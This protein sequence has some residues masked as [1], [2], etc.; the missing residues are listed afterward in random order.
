MKEETDEVVDVKQAETLEKIID[1]KNSELIKV[2]IPKDEYNDDHG[3]NIE[4]SSSSEGSSSSAGLKNKIKKNYGYTFNIDGFELNSVAYFNEILLGNRTPDKKKC[5]NVK[6]NFMETLDF[7]LKKTYKTCLTYLEKI[8]KQDFELQGDIDGVIINVENEVI[9][10]AKKDNPYSIFTSD[11]FLKHKKTYDIF[12]ESTFGLFDKLSKE[13]SSGTTRKIIQLKKLIFLIQFIKE[14]NCDEIDGSD[15]GKIK[16]RTE[17]NNTFHHNP[18]NDILLCIIV[19]GNYMQL[20]KQLMNTCL[21]AKNWGN[22]N[23]NKK[24][25]N[26]YEY[27]KILRESKVPF[28]IVYCP[29]FYERSSQFFNPISKKYLEDK[30]MESEIKLNNLLNENQKLK[31]EIENQNAKIKVQDTKIKEQDTKIKEQDTKLKKQDTKIEELEKKFMLME[32]KK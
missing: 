10:N 27:F 30:E 14:I 28:L 1:P 8:L 18:S 5:F 2:K 21:F 9:K 23:E 4:V 17:F 24:M 7:K 12:C 15:E 19:D 32:M 29:R 26:L 11:N 25:P 13:K 3:S 31:Q 22:A 16:F 20:V 6:F